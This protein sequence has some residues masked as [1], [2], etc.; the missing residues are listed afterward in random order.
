MKF[1]LIIWLV[2]GG[3]GGASITTAE[4][5]S[6]KACRAALAKAQQHRHINGVCVEK[7]WQE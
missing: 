3:H 4:F 5:N 6:F 1:I 7:G 2:T